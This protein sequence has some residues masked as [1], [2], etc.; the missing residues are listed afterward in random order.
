MDEAY[1]AAV[2]RGDTDGIRRLLDKAAC[3]AGYNK[4]VY[5]GSREKEIRPGHMVTHDRDYAET[6]GPVRMYYLTDETPF[7][8]SFT[9]LQML[10]GAEGVARL[11][12]LYRFGEDSYILTDPVQVQPADLVLYDTAGHVVSL[13]ERF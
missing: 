12:G 9:D 2:E 8:L 7:K 1:L 4:L 13:S 6:F 5:R 11:T 3:A 10:G